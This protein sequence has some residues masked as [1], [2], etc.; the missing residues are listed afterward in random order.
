MEGSCRSSGIYTKTPQL[1]ISDL[2]ER[3]QEVIIYAEKTEPWPDNFEPQFMDV[4]VSLT[5]HLDTN[6]GGTMFKPVIPTLLTS[7]LLWMRVRLP[8]GTKVWRVIAGKCLLRVIGCGES[9]SRIDWL[10]GRITNWLKPKPKP[11]VMTRA[12]VGPWPQVWGISYGPGNW[13]NLGF[14]ILD[15]IIVSQFSQQAG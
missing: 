11:V 9:L 13:L 14:V 3:A 4:N 7:T 5:R 6:L 10:L 1:A 8:N 15:Q 2:T 12:I